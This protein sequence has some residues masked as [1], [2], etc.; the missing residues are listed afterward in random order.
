MLGLCCCA[1]VDHKLIMGSAYHEIEWNT[2]TSEASYP[3]RAEFQEVER[4][5]AQSKHRAFLVDLADV[6]FNWIVNTEPIVLYNGI[7]CNTAMEAFQYMNDANI[8]ESF[9]R[10]A[11]HQLVANTTRLCH[12]DNEDNAEAAIRDIRNLTTDWMPSGIPLYV[13]KHE[14]REVVSECYDIGSS[15]YKAYYHFLDC[16]PFI[17]NDRV[18]A[19]WECL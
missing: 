15:E 14:C 2:D 16:I 10:A 18:K 1:T 11:L 13:G 8:D 17:R 5:L 9:R 4:L 7:L 12:F 19:L 6:I 3:T